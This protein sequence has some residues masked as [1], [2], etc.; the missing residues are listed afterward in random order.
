MTDLYDLTAP[1][2]ATNLSL[3]SDLLNKA[4]GLK[5]NLSATLEQAL[6]DKLKTEAAAKWKKDNAAAI[7]AYNEFVAESG[8]LSDEYREF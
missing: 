1:K 4:R 8:L 6:N 5:I 3:N 7:E 2:K